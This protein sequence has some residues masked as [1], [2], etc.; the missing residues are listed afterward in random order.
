MRG[1]HEVVVQCLVS[2]LSILVSILEI[3]TMRRRAV[4][5]NDLIFSK[6]NSDPWQNGEYT[7]FR[8]IINWCYCRRSSPAPPLYLAVIGRSTDK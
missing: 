8:K 1:T 7:E 6:N 2:S 5:F 3:E 4:D